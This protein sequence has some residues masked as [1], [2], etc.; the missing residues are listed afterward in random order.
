MLQLYYFYLVSERK[1]LFCHFDQ[2][3]FAIVALATTA[4]REKSV[5]P[6]FSLIIDFSLAQTGFFSTANFFRFCRARAGATL[7]MTVLT[8]FRS[9]TIASIL[10][11]RKRLKRKNQAES[12]ISYR[13]PTGT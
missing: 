2:A 10:M 5:T 11:L 1:P 7:E 8:G 6:I 3:D 12:E 9:G 13:S 4:E